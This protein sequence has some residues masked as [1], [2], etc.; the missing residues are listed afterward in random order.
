MLCWPF[1]DQQRSSRYVNTCKKMVRWKQPLALVCI[2]H[3]RRSHY[4]IST[5]PLQISSSDLQCSSQEVHTRGPALLLLLNDPTKREERVKKQQISLHTHSMN[6]CWHKVKLQPLLHNPH[7]SC[8][9]KA[10]FSHRKS[11]VAIKLYNSS[12]SGREMDSWG[13]SSL[14]FSSAPSCSAHFKPSLSLDYCLPVDYYHFMNLWL[15]DTTGLTCNIMD[16]ITEPWN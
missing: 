13:G 8:L 4:L 2:Q 5:V 16:I 14:H 6:N 3:Y 9:K 1:R 11:F 10:S 15:M 7:L 12:T